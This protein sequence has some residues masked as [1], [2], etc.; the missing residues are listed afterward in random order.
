MYIF[1]ERVKEVFSSNGVF[2]KKFLI[3]YCR[4]QQYDLAIASSMYAELRLITLIPEIF[5]TTNRDPP[6]DFFEIMSL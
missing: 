2:S 6:L 4:Y 3:V 5:F 1:V